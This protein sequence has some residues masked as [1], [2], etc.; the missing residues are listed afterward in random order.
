MTQPSRSNSAS[1]VTKLHAQIGALESFLDRHHQAEA[2]RIQMKRENILPPPDQSNH[3]K[4]RQSMTLAARRRY[5]RERNR[6][7][8]R[9]FLLFCTACALTW[10]LIGAG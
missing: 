3:R 6:T 8:V 4:A 1:D 9:F 5:L 2:Q 7:S 10:W